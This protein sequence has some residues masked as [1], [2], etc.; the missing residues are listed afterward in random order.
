MVLGLRFALRLLTVWVVIPA[1]VL[2]QTAQ[3]SQP[4][5]RHAEKICKTLAAW[6]A[7]SVVFVEMRDGSQHIGQ[8]GALAASSFEVVERSG[9]RLTLGYAAVDR[10]QK[11]DF[12]S[13]NQVVFHHRHGLVVGLVVVGALVGFLI[14]AVVE[15]RKS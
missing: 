1:L 2:C 11:A 14:F 7:D 12:A 5:S 13:A 4:L 3:P 10:V 6:P 9:N 15:L 8:L